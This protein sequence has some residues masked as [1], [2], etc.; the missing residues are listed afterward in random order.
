MGILVR[1]LESSATLID[2]YA[3][4]PSEQDKG[5][6]MRRMAKKLRKKLN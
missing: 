2:R 1:M 4:K 5:R 6:Q 3:K